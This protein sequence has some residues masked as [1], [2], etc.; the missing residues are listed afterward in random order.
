[1]T[2]MDRINVGLIGYGLG[3]SVFHAPLIGSAPRLRLAAVVTS[4][5]EQVK[6]QLPGVD[7]LGT[8]EE[9]LA[10][11]DIGMVVVA[12]PSTT[13]FE[14]A[15]A[16]LRAGKHV[17]VDKPFAA[18]VREANELI[19]LAAAKDQLLS[20]FQNRRWDGDFLTVKQ[21]LADGLLGNVLFFESHFDRFK[22]QIK[23]GWKEAAV[24]GAGILYDLG[25]HLIDQALQLFGMPDAITADIFP[26][27]DKA[28]ADDYFHLIL[29]Y[30][31]RRA[32]LH[33]SALVRSPG[34][35]FVIHGDGGSFTK[36]GMDVQEDSLTVGKRPGDAEWGLEL[37]GTYGE[38]VTTD[39]IRRRIPTLAGAYEVY[40]QG[41]AAA[42]L[43]GAPV[44]VDPATAR[45]G[46]KVMEAAL[47]S[48]QERR[49]VEMQS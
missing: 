43:D 41:F 49:T 32:I 16:A 12:S 1:M 31:R 37:P 19:E 22:L 46:L 34:P 38:L 24:P 4:R 13:H 28:I 29:R 18:S 48:A 40:Y 10:N 14:I 25:A 3:G 45:D 15:R 39:G 42:I 11:P 6:K 23:Q 35:R 7:V 33:A 17:V 47:K 36:Y 8:V 30:G 44:P 27:R 5:R 9:L 21:C 2:T 20:V 26:Q